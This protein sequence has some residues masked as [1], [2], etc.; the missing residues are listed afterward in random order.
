VASNAF[1]YFAT[2]TP[3]AANTS[4]FAGR[5]DAPGFSHKRGF[6]A[7]NFSLVLTSTTPGAT[8]YLTTD[9]PLPSASNGPI[10]T[11]PL[12][13]TN[14]RII[15]ASATAPGWLPSDPHTHSF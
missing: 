9:G 1:G 10:Y 7:T 14:S 15:R 2:P 5:T 6:Y 8:I 13:I 4:P 11:A 3:G 12:L